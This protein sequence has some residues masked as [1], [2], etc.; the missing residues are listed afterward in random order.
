MRFEASSDGG[1]QKGDGKGGK[2]SEASRAKESPE[3]V[4]LHL[5]LVAQWYPF[6]L[7]WFRVS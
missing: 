6:P 4:R 7:F 5:C 2:A 1:Y 3:L